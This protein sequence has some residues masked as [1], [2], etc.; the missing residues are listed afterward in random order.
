MKTFKLDDKNN[1][2]VN[3]DIVLCEGDEAL[4]QDI[5]TKLRLI[6]GEYPF[7]INYGLD[8]FNLIQN[9]N[10]AVITETI[11]KELESDSRISQAIID[12]IST[13]NNTLILNIKIITIEGRVLNV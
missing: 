11:I 7:N 6:K 4:L 1:L 8:Y 9:N 12:K 5:N 3:S 13:S 10:R 2:V